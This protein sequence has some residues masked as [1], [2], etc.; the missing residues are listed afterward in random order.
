M[1]DLLNGILEKLQGSEVAGAYVFLGNDK[2]KANIG[3]MVKNHDTDNYYAL[4]DAGTNW[5]EAGYHLEFYMKKEN[6]VE[7]L[8]THL[9]SQ[10]SRLLHMRLDELSLEEGT[11]TKVSMKLYMVSENT[12]CVEV[13][14]LG[15]GEIRR[16]S[17]KA[18]REEFIIY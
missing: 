15:F 4:L 9:P 12:L 5:Y 3:M 8:V 6:D 18:W 16:A 1:S 14:D 13:R 17:D 10:A 7:L 2:L 11:V